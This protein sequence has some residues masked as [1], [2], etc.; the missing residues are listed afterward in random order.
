MILAHSVQTGYDALSFLSDPC[1][2]LFGGVHRQPN[3]EIKNDGDIPSLPHTSPL[4]N[5]A[6]VQI[7]PFRQ[8]PGYYLDYT[9]T[10]SFQLLTS[11]TKLSPS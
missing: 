4:I 6:L 11:S 1:L 3:A 10:T 7:G 8:I 5:Y 9:T 2:G